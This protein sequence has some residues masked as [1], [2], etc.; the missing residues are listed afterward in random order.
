ML[1]CELT[2]MVGRGREAATGKVRFN[3]II[4]T[5]YYTVL[6][7]CD[8]VEGRGKIPLQR[9]YDMHTASLRRQDGLIAQLAKSS[10]E[11]SGLVW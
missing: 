6:S 7:V 4:N 9:S 5:Q 11:A 1:D 3:R 10:P 2:G 8:H